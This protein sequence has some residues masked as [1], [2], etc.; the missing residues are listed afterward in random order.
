MSPCLPQLSAKSFKRTS[1]GFRRFFLPILGRSRRFERMKQASGDG[2]NLVDGCEERAFVGLR[3]LIQAAD[4]SDELE[5]GCSN[6]LRSDWRIEIEER[7]DIP[8]HLI[9]R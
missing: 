5:R 6:L 8:A 7:L 1:S 3:R 9:P 2:G 4:F